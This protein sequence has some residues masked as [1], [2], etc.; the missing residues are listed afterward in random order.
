V[1]NH[2]SDWFY[3]NEQ[4]IRQI[5]KFPPFGHLLTVFG[6]SRREDR[7]EQGIQSARQMFL[8]VGGNHADNIQI[9][10]PIPS[11]ISKADGYFRKEFIIQIPVG[12]IEEFRD[13]YFQ[14]IETPLIGL[15]SEGCQISVLWNEEA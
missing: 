3:Q 6:S 10:E 4:G 15:R 9:G 14:K 5:L 7:L 8:K 11:R 12:R 2:S 1:A 13:Q